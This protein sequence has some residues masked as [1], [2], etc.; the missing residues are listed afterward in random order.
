MAFFKRPAPGDLKY[1]ATDSRLTKEC[2][3]KTSLEVQPYSSSKR[4][5]RESGNDESNT[6][7][8]FVIQLS[9]YVGGLS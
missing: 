8:S 2:I 3:E 5:R 9:R 6:P 1:L 7:Q 4:E